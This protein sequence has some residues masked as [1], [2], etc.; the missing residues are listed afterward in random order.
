VLQTEEQEDYVT[1]QLGCDFRWIVQVVS[2]S[3][4]SLAVQVIA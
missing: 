4:L 3:K 2:R 1:T